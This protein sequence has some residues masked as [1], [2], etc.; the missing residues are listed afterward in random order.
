MGFFETFLLGM[1]VG[2]II[3]LILTGGGRVERHYH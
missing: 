3:T 1:V 2:I